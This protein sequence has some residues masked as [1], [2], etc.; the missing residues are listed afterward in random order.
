MSSAK[1]LRC[2]AGAEWLQ[3]HRPPPD[4]A[5]LLKE[6]A[7]ALERESELYRDGDKYQ[8]HGVELRRMSAKLRRGAA[9]G[10]RES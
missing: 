9:G 2:G 1:C 6:A 4:R 3:G 8:P 7:R 10:M 5:E